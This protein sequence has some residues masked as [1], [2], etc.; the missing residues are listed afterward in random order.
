MIPFRWI[1]CRCYINNYRL[2]QG[3][4]RLQMLS[5]SHSYSLGTYDAQA[6]Q[7]ALHSWHMYI[8][9]GNRCWKLMPS[10]PSVNGWQELVD[11]YTS[12]LTPG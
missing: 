9:I 5:V 6:H 2:F 3:A 8:F 7:L 11:K 1:V 12:S 4:H 10:P